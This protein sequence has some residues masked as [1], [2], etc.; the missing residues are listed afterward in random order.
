MT[1]HQE[2]LKFQQVTNVSRETLERL[3]I[4][5]D[6]LRHWT[7]R[8]NLIAASTVDALWQRH[9]LD[10]AQLFEIAPAGVWQWL[11]LG[12][13]GGFPGLVIAA[14]AAESRPDSRITLVESDRRKAAFLRRVAREMGVTVIVLARRA[15]NL[16]P[17]NAGVLSARALAPLDTLLAFA[18]RHLSPGGVAL[19][20]KG[21]RAESE[22]ET[23]RKS[24]QF[25]LD[26]RRSLTDEKAF[27]LKITELA[28][29]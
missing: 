26:V 21:A 5:A 7:G 20:P 28:R 3:N 22:I 2:Q 17:Q 16:E 27:V 14:M 4:Y 9:F 13:G 24:W 25:A 8:I 12:S 23:A 10:S 29:V 15:E 11:D 6:L 19:F 18:E 1:A